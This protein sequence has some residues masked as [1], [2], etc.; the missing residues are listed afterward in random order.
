VPPP[1]NTAPEEKQP[2]TLL[3]KING[4]LKELI[5]DGTVAAILAKYIPAE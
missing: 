2:E 5:G 4:A 1:E 3:E